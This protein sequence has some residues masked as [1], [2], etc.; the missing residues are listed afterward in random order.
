[1][2]A[3]ELIL[4]TAV[5]NNV[6]PSDMIDTLF[7][8][9]DM[10]FNSCTKNRD[11]RCIDLA[12]NRYEDKGYKLPKVV[13]WNLDGRHESFP[14]K[15]NEEGIILVSGVSA[16]IFKSATKGTTPM[17]SMLETLNSDRYSSILV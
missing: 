8:F 6:A 9:S 7:I 17:E 4:K 1:M 3:Y 15:A 11:K 14:A 16:E 5:D 10:Q 12:R 13:F 2:A